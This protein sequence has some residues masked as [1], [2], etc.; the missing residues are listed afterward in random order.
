MGN[1]LED[2]SYVK[3]R[4]YIARNKKDTLKIAEY[5][6]AVTEGKD[7]FFNIALPSEEV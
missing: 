2:T 3:T 4:T 5:M 7:D 1:K 6:L